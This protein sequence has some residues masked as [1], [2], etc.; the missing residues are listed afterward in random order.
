MTDQPSVPAPSADQ[1]KQT[2]IRVYGF[3]F[4]T[5][6]FGCIPSFICAAITLV[7]FMA[8]TPVAGHVRNKA[9]PD[10]FTAEHMAYIIKTVWI[11]VLFALILIFGA[12]IYVWM[13]YDINPL[14]PCVDK[15]MAGAQAGQEPTPDMMMPCIEPFLIANRILFLKAGLAAGGPTILYL[16]LRLLR[17]LAR[18]RRSER[19]ANPKSWF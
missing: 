5:L 6:L 4:L 15:M 1:E 16:V 2:V 17:G 12:S 3:V 11:F 19:F 9:A 14:Q 10:S 7:M 8:V 13:N 18:A